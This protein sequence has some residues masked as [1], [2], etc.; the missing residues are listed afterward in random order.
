M[1]QGKSVSSNDENYDEINDENDKDNYENDDKHNENDENDDRDIK[2][3]CEDYASP[4][5]SQSTKTDVIVVHNISAT[6]AVPKVGNGTERPARMDYALEEC[7]SHN[8]IKTLKINQSSPD[9]Q[10]YLEMSLSQVHSF[11]Y[12]AETDFLS[13]IEFREVGAASSSDSLSRAVWSALFVACHGA[14]KA[15]TVSTYSPESPCF[16]K[17]RRVFCAIRPPGHHAH[18]NVATG[19]CYR[20]NALVCSRFAINNTQ[21]NCKRVLIVDFDFHYG[22]GVD[23]SFSD[24]KKFDE[25]YKDQ[26]YY[27]SL[28]SEDATSGY[29]YD[30]CTDPQDGNTCDESDRNKIQISTLD[31]SYLKRKTLKTRYLESLRRIRLDSRQ[32]IDLVVFSAGFDHYE[33]ETIGFQAYSDEKQ[34]FDKHSWD[35]ATY[36][37]FTQMVIQEHTEMN[38]NIKFVSLLEGG[39]SRDAL[40]YGLRGHLEGLAV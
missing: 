32:Q 39:Y 8:W 40:T 4:V 26:V 31:N 12:C 6:R 19:F 7:K 17:P 33:S 20:N 34:D 16:G 11:K 3:T 15:L 2:M 29:Y 21:L 9:T 13:D 38:A 27:I 24:R 22:G 5:V 28:V 10:K 25:F 1:G 36:R 30:S 37:E 18:S 35:R 14:K 23:K